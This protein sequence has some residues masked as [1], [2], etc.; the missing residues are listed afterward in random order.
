MRKRGVATW[1]SSILDPWK[2]YSAHAQKGQWNRAGGMKFIATTVYH[3]SF[4]AE[5][6]RGFRGSLLLRETF[7]HEIFQ[8]LLKSGRL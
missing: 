3:E 5:K 4:E 6:F 8:L 7:F 1:N 2:V